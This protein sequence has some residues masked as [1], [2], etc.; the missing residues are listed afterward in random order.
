MAQLEDVLPGS[1]MCGLHE[2]LERIDGLEQDIDRLEQRI[3]TWHKHDA[4]CRAIA[5]VPGIG[6]LTATAL[7]ATIGDAKAFKS[8]RALASFLGL[9]PRQS[10][11]GGKIRLGSISKRGD[12]YLRTLLIHGARSVLYH[13]KEPTAWQKAIVARRPANVA[14]VALANKMVRTAWAMLAQGRAYQ[15]CHVS[16]KPA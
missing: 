15:N 4:L 14:A 10:G 1:M 5:E 9:V 12:P 6:K 11:T 8:G 3:S 13:T 2:Q 7:I 16:A